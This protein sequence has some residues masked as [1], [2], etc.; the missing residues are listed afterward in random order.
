MFFEVIYW[1]RLVCK[2]YRFGEA[3]Y[4]GLQNSDISWTTR[5]LE[6]TLV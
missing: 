4:V 6:T 1:F 2:Y 3:C 5:K